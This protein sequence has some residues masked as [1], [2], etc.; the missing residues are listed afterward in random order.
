MHPNNEPRRPR[1]TW[2]RVQRTVV[3]TVSLAPAEAHVDQVGPDDLLVQYRVRNPRNVDVDR[4]HVVADS[5]WELGRVGRRAA[6][7]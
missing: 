1:S 3:R 7:R 4:A 6:R 5:D 2:W